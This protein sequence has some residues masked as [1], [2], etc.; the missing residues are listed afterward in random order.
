MK[1]WEIW[2]AG[3]YYWLEPAN[4]RHEL[5]GFQRCVASFVATSHQAG[6]VLLTLFLGV[7]L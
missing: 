3:G 1:R 2:T 4:G 5:P 6:K 7:R